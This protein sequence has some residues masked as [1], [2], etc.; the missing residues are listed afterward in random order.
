M[1]HNKV[2]RAAAKSAL[3]PLGLKQ[4]RNSRIWYDDRGWWALVVEFQPSG[5]QRGSYLNVGVVWM[6]YESEHWAFDIGGR[7]K[8]VHFATEGEEI[9][10]QNCMNIHPEHPSA[11]NPATAT[12]WD[13]DAQFRQFAD[14]AR[15]G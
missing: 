6:F 13:A 10:K 8:G 4:Q 7:V 15:W 11:A 5:F 3:T 1:D 12:K 14:R 2:I 9:E